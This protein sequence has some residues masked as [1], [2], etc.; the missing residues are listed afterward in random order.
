LEHEY[1]VC[2]RVKDLPVGKQA[3]AVALLVMWTPVPLLPEVL[4]VLS[5][6][7]FDYAGLLTWQKPKDDGYWHRSNG[8]YALMGKKGTPRTS[9]L[10]RHMIH[11]TPHSDGDYKPDVFRSLLWTAGC[12]AFGDSA[13]RLDLFGGY[14][15][16]FFPEYDRE[17][18]DFWED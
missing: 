11:E 18:W 15:Q 12:L 1:V 5:A 9:H 6:W 17:D 8:E 3:A 10:L 13:P 7:G 16:K 4:L 14:W 2:A